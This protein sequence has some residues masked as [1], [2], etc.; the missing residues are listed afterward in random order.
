MWI[1]IKNYLSC[2]PRG[3]D[4]NDQIC[5]KEKKIYIIRK[6]KIKDNYYELL[7]TYV[8]EKHNSY[9]IIDLSKSKNYL[10]KSI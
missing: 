6:S 7:V 10:M 5:V 4:E 1:K 8:H 2:K 9:T 3:F